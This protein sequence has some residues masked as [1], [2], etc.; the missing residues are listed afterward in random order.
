MGNNHHEDERYKKFYDRPPHGE[1]PKDPRLKE[2][3][4]AGTEPVEHG[5]AEGTDSDSSKR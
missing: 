5:A 3:M 4:E 2:A 1:V